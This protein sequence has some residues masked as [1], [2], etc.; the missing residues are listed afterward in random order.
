MLVRLWFWEK[1]GEICSV[2]CRVAR[3]VWMP[4]GLLALAVHLQLLLPACSSSALQ[5]CPPLFWGREIQS[6]AS[7]LI[8]PS[9]FFFPPPLNRLWNWFS[10]FFFG[11][12]TLLV[13]Y[14]RRAFWCC[15]EVNPLTWCRVKSEK[16]ILVPCLHRESLCALAAIWTFFKGTPCTSYGGL[17]FSPCGYI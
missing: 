8:Y 11:S 10:A 5:P 6:R 1:K 4:P 13:S 17:Y 14:R 7:S 3:Q 9:Y 15:W 2:V 12:Q 16:G